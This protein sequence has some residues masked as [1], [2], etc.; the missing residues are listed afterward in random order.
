MITLAGL[1]VIG[2][3]AADTSAREFGVAKLVQLRSSARGEMATTSVIAA[4]AA[5]PVNR[6]VASTPV[7]STPVA[8]AIDPPVVE[9]E[10]PNRATIAKSPKKKSTK[11]GGRSAGATRLSTTSR[12]SR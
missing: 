10:A 5:S 6:A 3:L 8:P 7:A 4:V 2:F 12:P 9:A 1:A 11:A